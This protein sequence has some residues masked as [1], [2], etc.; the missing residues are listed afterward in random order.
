MRQKPVLST[1]DRRAANRA[2][3][4][5]SSG[6]ASYMAYLEGEMAAVDP[7]QLPPRWRTNPY[8]PGIRHNEW[9]RG[10]ANADPLG[11]WHGRNE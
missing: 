1:R 9:N 8:P 2:M 11:D 5:N 10:K 3:G 4:H 7:Q 6:F